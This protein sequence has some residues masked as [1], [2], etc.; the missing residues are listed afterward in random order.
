MAT[1]RSTNRANSTS[2]VRRR[3]SAGSR[4]RTASATSRSPRTTV[5]RNTETRVKRSVIRSLGLSLFL[6][7]YNFYWFYAARRD[8]T[9]ELGT[10]D[11]AGLQTIGLLVPILNIFIIY[12]LYRD[13]SRLQS[14]V[15]LPAFSSGWYLFSPVLVAILAIG[16]LISLGF[17]F[18]TAKIGSTLEGILAITS[19]VM[20]LALFA[21]VILVLVFWG[22]VVS[23]LNLYWDTKLKGRAAEA[24]FN[25]D[26]V[27]IISLGL[28]LVIGQ[29]LLMLF[30]PSFSSGYEDSY[31]DGPSEV[32][33]L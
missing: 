29:F 32:Q 5:T 10:S 23:K 12:W 11:R 22:L 27:I 15:R 2:V 7:L 25:S 4:T 8:V 6:P 28:L 33:Q 17:A 13:I 14:K 20:V 19:I 1:P 26:E 16:A 24:P 30:L 3:P 18:D 31:R 9:T 21:A